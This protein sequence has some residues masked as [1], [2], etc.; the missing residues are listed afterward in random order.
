VIAPA[1]TGLVVEETHHFTVAF[2]VAALVSVL[3]LLGW[4]GMVRKVAPL[5]WPSL[6]P[7]YWIC[8][9]R[10]TALPG[11][12]AVLSPRPRA[13]RVVR[14]ALHAWHLARR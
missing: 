14:R 3:G 5:R 8:A 4:V 12:A 9:L 10:A 7:L 11:S 1:L 6:A 13:A 2:L